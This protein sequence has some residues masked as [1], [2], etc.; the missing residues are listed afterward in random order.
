MHLLTDLPRE[1]LSGASWSAVELDPEHGVVLML[2]QLRLPTEVHYHRFEKPDEIADAI[3]TMIVRG[4]PAIGI[5]AAYALALQAGLERGDVIVGYMS[6][7]RY[8][9]RTVPLTNR[10][11]LRSAIQNSGNRL[12]LSVINVRDGRTVKVTVHFNGGDQSRPNFAAN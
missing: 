12:R 5:S 10:Q 2:D 7:T 1:P 6:F 8:G 11:S 3:R 9:M 4:A